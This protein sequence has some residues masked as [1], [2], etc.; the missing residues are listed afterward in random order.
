MYFKSLTQY[1]LNA[2]PSKLLVKLP[3]TDTERFSR[4]TDLTLERLLTQ[5]DNLKIKLCD[6]K[7]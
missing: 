1:N 6:T 7:I 4:R 3:K 2:N 5:K